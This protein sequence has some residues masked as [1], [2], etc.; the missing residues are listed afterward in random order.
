MAHRIQHLRPAADGPRVCWIVTEAR[1][2]RLSVRRS[3]NSG[4]WHDPLHGQPRRAAWR[5][6]L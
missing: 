6:L 4:R 3:G 1:R 2:G 5:D